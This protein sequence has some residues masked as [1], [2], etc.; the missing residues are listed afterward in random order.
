MAEIIVLSFVTGRIPF[1]ISRYL[2]SEPSGE[3]SPATRLARH[4]LRDPSI[5]RDD[6]EWD[7]IL[8]MSFPH[9]LSRNPPFCAK[10]I[11]P[12]LTAHDLY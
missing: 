11:G 6:R 9:L 4:D 1:K 2:S 12:I 5:P 7:G 3:E 10:Q 8:K